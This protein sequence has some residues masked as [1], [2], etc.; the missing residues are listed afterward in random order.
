MGS[1]ELSRPLSTVRQQIVEAISAGEELLRAQ[2]KSAI[3]LTNFR[4]NYLAWESRTSAILENSF[5]VSGFLTSNP[6]QE[7]SATAVSLLDLKLTST[8]LPPERL[9][10][11]VTDIQEK[12]RV[13]RSVDSRLDVYLPVETGKPERSNPAK[14]APIFLVHGRDLVRREV[15]R[16]FL[17]TVTRRT[18]IVLAD[19]PNR[20]QDLLGKLL[21]NAQDACFAVVLLTADDIGGLEIDSVKPR[22]RQNV[23]FELGM[24]IALLGRDRVSAMTDP[25]IETPTD[26]SGVAYIPLTGD[27]WQLELVRELRA[28]GIEA[29]L[30]RAL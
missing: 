21:A 25:G 30:D 16:R 29:S 11:V 1:V 23:V 19:Q 10:E 24:F 22:A 27:S 13:L 8:R 26:F 15:I 4:E 12:V 14:D 3:E 9:S 20:G 28:A 6:K 7:F 18:V 2:P 17:E 5:K